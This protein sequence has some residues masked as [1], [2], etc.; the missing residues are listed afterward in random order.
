M[1]R[2]FFSCTGTF[3]S[4]GV[5]GSTPA[6][7][8]SNI[9]TPFPSTNQNTAAATGSVFG[10]SQTSTNQ[11][12]PFGQQPSGGA[13]TSP[14]FGGASPIVSQPGTTFGG[15]NSNTT[16]AASPISGSQTG[17][18]GGTSIAPQTSTFGTTVAGSMSQT[19][20]AQSAG[21]S[22]DTKQDHKGLP[23]YTPLDKLTVEERTAFQAPKF[24][25]GKIPVCPPPRELC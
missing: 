14:G 19:P 4:Q 11:N 24:V 2:F 6:F 21:G 23:M 12:A 10:Q 18:F 17:V 5:F 15:G 20:V 13:L 1:K 22:G 8:Q 3:G 7:A 9:S 25:L 16:V